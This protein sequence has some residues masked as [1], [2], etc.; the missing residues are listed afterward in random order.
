M[1]VTLIAVLAVLTV[2]LLTA[3]ATA[4][5]TVSRI[6][7]R[8]WV[9][10][11]LAGATLAELYLERPQRL[12]ISAGAGVALAAFLAGAGIASTAERPIT[13]AWRV[14]LVGTLILLLGQVLP[15]AAARR[16]PSALVP[17]LVR[18][19]RVVDFALAPLRLLGAALARPV[20][21]RP[22]QTPAEEARDSIEDLLRE[23]AMEGVGQGEE[24]AILA[25]VVQFGEKRVGDVMTPRGEVFAVDAALP[26][27][28]IARRV[29]QS[30]YSRVPAYRG[31]LDEVVGMVH[32][33]DVF[34]VADGEVEIDVRP[35]AFSAPEQPCNELLFALLR[36]SRHLAVVRDARGV[37]L[38]IVTLEDLLEELVGDIRDEHDEPMTTREFP[39]SSTE[40]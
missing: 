20:V 6:W 23:G 10:R 18:P 29:A 12:L 3:A 25:G 30:G 5:R 36:A 2:G 16:W 15:R 1:S 21:G 11:R 4:V 24:I 28:E 27:E 13:L 9:E 26:A 31:T 37:T 19:L 40:P 35:V 39:T 34:Q 33:F 22:V 38:G 8:H 17:V 14:V 7:L 32:A